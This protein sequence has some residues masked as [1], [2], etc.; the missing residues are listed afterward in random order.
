M[1]PVFD[2]PHSNNRDGADR[3]WPESRA[4]LGAGIGTVV[5]TAAVAAL[6][7]AGSGLG[8]GPQLPAIA[9]VLV[10]ISAIMIWV[11]YMITLIRDTV[12]AGVYMSAFWV[13]TLLVLFVVFKTFG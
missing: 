3:E 10:A 2:N 12:H 8:M 1:V 9:Y 11:H 4:L 6:A 5:I 13:L 7:A